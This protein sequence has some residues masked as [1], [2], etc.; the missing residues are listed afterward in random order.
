MPTYDIICEM[1][2]SLQSYWEKLRTWGIK[3]AWNYAVAALRNRSI[4]RHLVASLERNTVTPTRGITII[5]P[6]GGGNSLCKVM[7]DL[8]FN[9]K[10]LEIPFQTFDLS[11]RQSVPDEDIK[12][13]LTPRNQFNLLKYDHVL[14]MF[15]APLPD[16][17]PIRRSRIIFWEFES[18]LVECDNSLDN[19]REAIGMSDFDVKVFSLLL[20]PGTPVRKIPYPFHFEATDLPPMEDIR[21]H[22]GIASDD[23]M[24]FFNFDFNS[25]FHRKN[26]DGAIKAFAEAFRA[27]PHTKLVF[28]TMGAKNHPDKLACLHALARELGVF[29]QFITI[30]DYLPQRDLYGLTNACDVYLSLHRG[31]GFG[32][33][34]AE[35]MSLGKAVITTDYSAPTEFC[36]PENSIPI[37]FAMTPVESWQV[38]NKT[39]RF[40]KEWAEPNIH[41]AS[42]ALRRLYNSP[43]LR[44]K[45]GVSAKQTIERAFSLDKFKTAINDYLRN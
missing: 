13:I 15:S 10:A 5:A 16:D 40:V 42:K 9:L 11:E 38:D 18:G 36:T 21:K 35:A 25:S 43:E 29:D 14:E 34:I 20:A 45:L 26:P 19:K 33:G 28:K 12:P 2:M 24:V 22:F 44:S 8:A 32:L 17:L 41:E 4:Q 30:T 1:L 27:I 7:R 39:Y 31:E 3:G 37:P 6:L 23:F